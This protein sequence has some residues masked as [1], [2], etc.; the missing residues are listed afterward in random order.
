MWLWLG[1]V[2]KEWGT[3]QREKALGR[4]NWILT[5]YSLPTGKGSVCL[6]NGKE[7]AVNKN[8]LRGENRV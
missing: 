1:R 2:A 3:V 8:P 4:V 7:V 5:G 6:C